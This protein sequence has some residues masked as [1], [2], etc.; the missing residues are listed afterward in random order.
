MKPIVEAIRKEYPVGT[1]IELVSMND[2]QAPPK[3]TLGMVKGVDDLGQILMS[4]RTGSSLNLIIGTDEFK[5]VIV[6]KCYGQERVWYDRDKAIDFF[7]ECYC[8][9]EGAEQQRYSKIIKQI[10]EGLGYCSDEL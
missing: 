3:G 10:E 4:W 5:K 8:A 7:C 9:S 6:T 1:M 2:V